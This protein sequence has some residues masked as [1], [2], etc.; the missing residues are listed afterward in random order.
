MTDKFVH[1]LVKLCSSTLTKLDVY[2]CKTITKQS[3]IFLSECKGLENVEFTGIN[4]NLPSNLSVDD[5]LISL[6]QECNQ[7]SSFQWRSCPLITD[8]SLCS[9][10]EF[11]PL[12]ILILDSSANITQQGYQFLIDAS[13]PLQYLSLRTC[14]RMTTQMFSTLLSVMGKKL[15]KLDIS[16]NSWVSDDLIALISTT[17]KNLVSLGIRS[18]PRVTSM[19]VY[20]GLVDKKGQLYR[21]I[22]ISGNDHFSTD[23]VHGLQLKFGKGSILFG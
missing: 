1:K 3:I 4:H 5:A 16:G 2:N 23:V 7:I 18:V 11:C 17:C 9:L 13:P 12:K 19:G 20:R 8:L 22:Y 6:S 10:A 15:L 14:P 21:E